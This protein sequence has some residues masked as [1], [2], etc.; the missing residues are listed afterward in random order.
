MAEE[1]FSVTVNS[2]D[3]PLDYIY[4]NYYNNWTTTPSTY[5][6]TYNTTIYMYQFICPRC[7]TTNWGELDK[8]IT[9]KG[10]INSRKLCQAKL[11]A[12]KEVVDY[13]V[14]VD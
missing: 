11:K 4:P 6:W 9:C 14:P 7:A 3:P 10:K 1:T 12:T 5:T 8:I 2:G 13:E